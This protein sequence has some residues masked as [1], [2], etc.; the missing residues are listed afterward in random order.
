[1]ESLLVVQLRESTSTSNKFVD[2]MAKPLS[3]A[4]PPPNSGKLSFTID[5]RLYS[6]TDPWFIQHRQS[7]KL[8]KE[9]RNPTPVYR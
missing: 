6:T 4:Q 1:M 5:D 7:Q 8:I 3:R 9:S 2:T